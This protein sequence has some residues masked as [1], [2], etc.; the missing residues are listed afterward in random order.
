MNDH[1]P[2]VTTDIN[3]RRPRFDGTINLGHILTFVGF[4][5]AGFSAYSTLDK[6]IS[7]EEVERAAIKDALEAR[8]AQVERA[9]T[10]IETHLDRI[11][12]RLIQINGPARRP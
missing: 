12:N 11:D 2:A 7:V 9:L 4:M 5:A 6:R 3:L 8:N 10:R 1:H